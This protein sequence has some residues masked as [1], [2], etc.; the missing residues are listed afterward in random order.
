[1]FPQAFLPNNSP[2]PTQ[3]LTTGYT[4]NPYVWNEIDDKW[5][6]WGKENRLIKQAVLATYGKMKGKYPIPR[7]R[8]Q[9]NPKDDSGN[10]ISQSGKKSVQFKSNTNTRTGHSSAVT[11]PGNAT[12]S[13]LKSN[14]NLATS[15]NSVSTIAKETES[16]LDAEAEGQTHN[17]SSDC[18]VIMNIIHPDVDYSSDSDMMN[19]LMQMNGL[20]TYMLWNT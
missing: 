13:I 4:L 15:T 20:K 5:T 9:N 8:N 11:H 2:R 17:L 18:E 12:D 3:Q 16:Q 19:Q 7:N 10:Q 1:M 14:S 6:K